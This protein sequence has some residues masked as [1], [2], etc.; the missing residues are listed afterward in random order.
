MSEQPELNLYEIARQAGRYP[1][2]AY[3]F[4]QEGLAFTVRQ[5]HGDPEQLP[6]GQR[7]VS[8]RQLCQGL[9]RLAIQKWGRLAATVLAQWRITETMDFGRMVFAMI[10]HGLMQK[11]DEDSIEDFRDVYV[12][13]QAF[14]A[15]EMDD[16]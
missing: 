12:F 6:P 1:A 14:E 8:G 15:D 9:R 16:F 10:D 11:R 7:H 3:I 4:L 2:D 5:V 13:R